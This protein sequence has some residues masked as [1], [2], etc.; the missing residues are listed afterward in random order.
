M[1]WP[2]AIEAVYV[3][4]HPEKEKGRFERLIPHLLETGVPEDRIRITAPCWGSDLAVD[5]IFKIYDPFLPRG[6]PSFSFKAAGLTRSELSL[7]AN[8][9]SVV[10][11]A[12]T[13]PTGKMVMTLESDVWLRRDFVQR[14]NELLA[15]ASGP[16]DYI[17]LGEGV[18]TRPP[19]APVSYYC[20]TRAWTPPHQW[21][22]RCTDS[23]LFTSDYMRKLAKTFVPFKEIIDWEMNFQIAHHEG[24][25]LWAD[26]PLAEQGT[27]YARMETS[28][29]A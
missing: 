17:S 13:I 9:A 28:L 7:G 29:P 12:A 11:S 27:C 18:G 6:I 20:E 8:F 4:C 26:P 1:E 23:M 21:V 15:S 25:A 19:D 14:L 22:F 16:W 3:I 24:V 10:Q 2:D 5:D